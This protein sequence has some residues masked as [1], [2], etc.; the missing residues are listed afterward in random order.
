MITTE[1]IDI[2][3]IAPPS[4][5]STMTVPVSLL[6]LHGWLTRENIHCKIIDVKFGK[7]NISLYIA[8]IDI[9]RGKIVEEILK[10]K[11]KYIGITCFTT[12]FWE[13]IN[14]SN[15]I[16][17]QLDCTI[18]VGGVHAN[19]RPQDFFFDGSPIDIV[20]SGDGQ[21]P[22]VEIINNL[23][24]NKDLLGIEGLT[25]VNE[26]G[27][28][29]SQ[30]VA[31]FKN[32]GEMPNPD[33]PQ[34][35]MEYY[36]QPHRGIIRSLFASGIHVFTTIGC[37]FRCTFCGNRAKKV[38]YR[39]IPKVLD[40]IEGLIEQYNID[41]FYIQDDTFCLDKSRVVEFAQGL[42]ER[43]MQVSWGM[44]TRVNL[45]NEDIIRMLKEVGC[46]QIDFGV[47]SGSDA[48]LKRMKKGV[49]VEQTIKAFELCK[50][51]RMRTFAN[52]M[53]NTPGETREDVE[54]TMNLLKKT[55]PTGIGLGL[56]VPFPG[57]EI[58]EQYVKPPL[59]RDEYRLLTHPDLYFKVIDP[60]FHMAEHD[61]DLSKLRI[62]TKARFDNFRTF[63]DFTLNPN[64]LKA[65][66]KSKRKMQYLKA[67]FTTIFIERP[68]KYISIIRN[69]I[70]K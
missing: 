5:A 14:L 53:F 2:C 62:K 8:Q 46:I 19:I 61:L 25:Y 39:P 15:V 4:R 1:R 37:P 26:R 23:N 40:E 27:E 32:L 41:A 13:V 50:K 68:I 47:E 10:H 29:I 42:E 17:S 22:L 7:P 6:Y 11:P 54:L 33:Y 63:I 24:S 55:R 36:M 3:L 18:I 45:I 34:L 51:Y 64:Y 12:D 35:D 30:G 67:I 44:E 21:Q 70:K 20:V 66:Y 69:W 49:T 56:T 59:T 58:Y 52:I 28:I 38:R 9:V 57:T 16:K 65:L 31:T 43:N 60:R 48:A